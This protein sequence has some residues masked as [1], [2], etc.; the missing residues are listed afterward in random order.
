MDVIPGIDLMD[1]KCICAVHNPF[2][3]DRLASHDPST[4]AASLASQGASRF[5]VADLD[6]ARMGRPMNLDAVKKL[7][8]S[9]VPV[10]L[11]GGIR[12]RDTAKKMLDLGVDR[13]VIGTTA[14]LDDRLADEI[15]AELADKTI[16]SI[17][18]LNGYVAVRDWQARTD[19]L[20]EDFAMRMKTLG[21]KRI[22]FTDVARKGM[23]G[24]INTHQLKRMALKLNMPII[25]SG[26]ISSLNDVRQLKLLE[27]LGL[28][29]MIVVTALYSGSINL[30]D[31]IAIAAQ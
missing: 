16:V 22:V 19:E 13:I 4:V 20:A 2:A 26:G 3:A 15:L 30:A 21:A 5:Y 31:A 17:A 18:S 25:A 27:P 14:A 1:G 11:G 10:D 7:V 12:T 23:R 9:G 24:G 6:G 28:E 29:G 8:D